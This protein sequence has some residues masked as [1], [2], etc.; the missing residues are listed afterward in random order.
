[1]LL[2]LLLLLLLMM[3]MCIMSSTVCVHGACKPGFAPVAPNSKLHLAAPARNAS[4]FPAFNS[5]IGG[6]GWRKPWRFAYL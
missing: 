2:L 4:P 6:A 3:M 5:M 1:V